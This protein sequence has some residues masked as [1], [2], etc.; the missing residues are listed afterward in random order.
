MTSG[1]IPTQPR[2]QD[3]TAYHNDT[4]MTQ[5]EIEYARHKTRLRLSLNAAR[6]SHHGFAGA[7]AA[8]LLGDVGAKYKKF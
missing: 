3:Y 5:N 2:I 8:F 7:S 6:L 1:S 4:A